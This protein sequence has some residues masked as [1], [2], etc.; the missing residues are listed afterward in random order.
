[1]SAAAR[2]PDAALIAACEKALAFY[3]EG[4]P[5]ADLPSSPAVERRQDRWIRKANQIE[6]RAA[7]MRATTLAGLA[8][9]ARLALGACYDGLLNDGTG[10][11]R[12]IL[13]ELV[14]LGEQQP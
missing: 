13:E 6:Q 4:L 3:R 7:D 10:I 9:K 8:A 14:A 1:M 11:V 2:S 5:D 12:T